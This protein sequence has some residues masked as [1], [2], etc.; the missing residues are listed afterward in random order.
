MEPQP[1][2]AQDSETQRA[3]SVWGCRLGPGG[4]RLLSLCYSRKHLRVCFS[5][6]LSLEFSFCILS[7]IPVPDQCHTHAQ[8]N[9]HTAHIHPCTALEAAHSVSSAVTMTSALCLSALVFEETHT[10]KKKGSERA[11]PSPESEEPRSRLPWRRRCCARCV[12]TASV[13]M[14][15]GESE[16]AKGEVW[17]KWN[18]Q[19]WRSKH[20]SWPGKKIEAA[21]VILKQSSRAHTHK[22]PW[23][24]RS[25]FYLPG[26]KIFTL[27]LLSAV[28]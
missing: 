24:Q 26:G 28:K 9:P 1:Q 6:R 22:L 14:E 15:V 10:K 16:T 7:G 11:T 3:G 8:R 27:P 19:R 25:L 20:G 23:F 2:R 17:R 13:R 18:E 4:R 12:C 21:V 5:H